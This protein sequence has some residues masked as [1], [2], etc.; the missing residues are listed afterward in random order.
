MLIRTPTGMREKPP[1]VNPG[2]LR[3][4]VEVIAGRREVVLAYLFGS[5]ARGRATPMSDLDFAVLL[6]EAIARAA[7]I[8]YQIA[9]TQDL[10]RVFG[11]DEVQVVILN[12]APPLLA[13][14]VV[15]HGRELLCR[16]AAARVRFRVRAT[17]RYLDTQPL[18]KVQA[19]ATARRIREGR[20]GRR[21]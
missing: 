2:T 8:D 18:R 7:Y 3:A 21:P 16:D 10:T 14:A 4:A 6:S 11:S 20:F 13:Y 5:H 19:E 15:V 9:L 17:Q 12:Q 1:D